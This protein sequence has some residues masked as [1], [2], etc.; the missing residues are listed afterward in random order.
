MSDLFLP[1][2]LFDWEVLE[3]IEKDFQHMNLSKEEEKEIET[4]CLDNDILFT[5]K[6]KVC[7]NKYSLLKAKFV[8]ALSIFFNCHKIPI[9]FLVV[10]L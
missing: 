3:E 7:K 9:C 4:E 6:C 1:A 5:V 2:D 10:F 8:N